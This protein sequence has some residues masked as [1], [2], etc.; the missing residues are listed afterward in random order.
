MLILKIVCL[1]IC[2]ALLFVCYRPKQFAEKI[3]KKDEITD[4][5]ILKIKTVSLAIS[6]AVFAL[7]I[8]FI[9]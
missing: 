7:T 2:A 5:L 3:L 6:I 9:R 8:I 4:A 1:I